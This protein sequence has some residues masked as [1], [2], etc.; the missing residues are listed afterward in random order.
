MWVGLIQSVE[1][2]K[3]KTY[4]SPEMP[5][6]VELQHQLF[7]GSPASQP[8]LQILDLPTFTTTW[9]NFLKSLP[10]LSPPLPA[11][12]CGHFFLLNLHINPTGSVLLEN[13]NNTPPNPQS[14]YN[15]IAA[16]IIALAY[17]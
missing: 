17:H 1:G 14:C 7:P 4:T 8:T 10:P 11:I 6:D 5:L 9:A 16:F 13:P 3:R 12:D 15:N 2:L